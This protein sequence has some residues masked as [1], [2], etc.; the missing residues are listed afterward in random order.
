MR[1]S[2]TKNS[3]KIEREAAAW[4]QHAAAHNPLAAFN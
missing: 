1:D 4:A 3:Q 2:M